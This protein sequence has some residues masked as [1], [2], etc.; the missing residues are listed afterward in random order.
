MDDAATMSPGASRPLTAGELARLSPG[1]V[2]ALGQRGV[3]PSLLNRAHRAA[4]VAG[5]WRGA[6]P[7]L[8]RPARIFWPGAR[9][10][11]ADAPPEVFATLQHELQHLLDYAAG[12]LSGPG[13]LLRPGDW[14]YGYALTP[15]SRWAD[16]G[17]EQ[18][19]SIAEHLWLMEQGRG[20]LVRRA[21]GAAPA[22]LDV[23][24]SVIP[25]AM[26]RDLPPGQAIP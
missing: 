4:R 5:L 6:A 26:P 10:D 13:Y 14:R 9:K 24:R 21:L 20:D 1:L 19:A 2:Q 16:F 25:W 17:A 7:I 18:R 3:S 8:A 12:A 23:Y 22:S 11:F 15:A